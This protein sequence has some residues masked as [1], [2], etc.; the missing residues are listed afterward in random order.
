[1]PSRYWVVVVAF[2]FAYFYG[3]LRVQPHLPRHPMDLK[4]D[5]WNRR[6]GIQVD[7]LGVAD[8][9]NGKSVLRAPE[10]ELVFRRICARLFFLERA[11][12]SGRRDIDSYV[13]WASRDMNTVPDYLVN[14]AMGTHQNHHWASQDALR[15]RIP[16]RVIKI[17]VDGGLRGLPS[18]RH[19]LAA[20]GYVTYGARGVEGHEVHY[21]G[22]ALMGEAIE[23][24]AAP[25]AAPPGLAPGA[26]A[27]GADAEG[28]SG[29]SQALHNMQMDGLIMDHAGAP[30]AAAHA[31]ASMEVERAPAAA[32]DGPAARFGS[33]RSDLLREWFEGEVLQHFPLVHASTVTELPHADMPVQL[34]DT[35]EKLREL[36]TK[37]GYALD[38]EDP[39]AAIGME[40]G[41]DTLHK[42][43]GLI[44]EDAVVLTQWSNV[45]KVHHPRLAP[46]AEARVLAELTEKGDDKWL[47]LARDRN[48]VI[49]APADDNALTRC[50]AGFLRRAM[51]GIYPSS[52]IFV[53]AIPNTAG[54]NTVSSI[55]DLWSSPLLSERWSPIVRATTYIPFPFEMVSS[56]SSGTPRHFRSGLGIFSLMQAGPISIPKVIHVDALMH[57]DEVKTIVVDM[58]L[59]LLT[60]FLKLA[61]LDILEGLSYRTH[62]KSLTSTPDAPRVAVEVVMDARLSELECFAILKHLRRHHLPHDTFFGYKHLAGASDALLLECG[63]SRLFRHFW[64]L[65][66]Q[67]LTIGPSRFLVYTEALMDTWTEVMQQ[68]FSDN[69]ISG[70]TRLRCRPSHHGGRT[71]ATPAA[72]TTQLTTNRR[73][74]GK[75]CGPGDLVAEI[76]PRGDLGKAEDVVLDSLMKH[77]CDSVGLSFTKAADPARP[78]AGEYYHMPAC[79]PRTPA[80]ALKV[81]AQTH[82]DIRRLYAALHGQSILVG[83][84]HV[85]V[86]VKNDLVELQ[87]QQ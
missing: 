11:G 12:W 78:K 85:V 75:K 80:G 39:W 62:R 57:V 56:T 42:L 19:R 50:L 25:P 1:M 44:P 72:T 36:L 5:S 4:W 23:A 59:D 51:S 86:E 64:P 15:K 46:V 38:C 16:Q 20:I 71:L 31:M 3:K 2:W 76:A 63:D 54:S 84:D 68:V 65:C 33:L 55:T 69:T 14:A 7:C 45:L 87:I 22:L 17:Y 47:D 79:P 82:G 58:R 29:L 61:R 74:S 35:F 28:T 9:V 77:A 43:L 67:M 53:T 27:A 32:G 83:T 52:V 70:A 10:L 21:E 48:I 60:D 34:P 6:L 30:L 24:T 8:V 73:R 66:T 40:I 18:D 26:P 49:W 37:L 81:L 41:L 13:N